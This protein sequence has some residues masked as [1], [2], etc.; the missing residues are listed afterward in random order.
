M[1]NPVEQSIRN[2]LTNM[3]KP[4]HLEV[5]NE[6]NMHNVPK[7][8]NLIKHELSSSISSLSLTGVIGRIHFHV[9]LFKWRSGNL[10]TSISLTLIGFTYLYYIFLIVLYV[11]IYEISGSETHFK[12][13]V[14][15]TEFKEK[16][17]LQ[18]CISIKQLRN[19][20][21]ET[22]PSTCMYQ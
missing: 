6:S 7:G 12:V 13:I 22:Y 5:I 16:K 19:W 15:S 11:L 3:F 10:S 17:L 14:V 18:V 20:Y 1:Q 21:K 9:Y 2:K 8:R 4:E